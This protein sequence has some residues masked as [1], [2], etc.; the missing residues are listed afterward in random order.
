MSKRRLKYPARA[1]AVATLAQLHRLERWTGRVGFEKRLAFRLAMDLSA[2]RAEAI[3]IEDA[4][5]QLANGAS[6]SEEQQESLLIRLKVRLYSQL[7]DYT[8]RL[9]GNLK[10]AIQHLSGKIVDDPEAL[11]RET[12][13]Y[14]RRR[15]YAMRRGAKRAKKRLNRAGNSKARPTSRRLPKRKS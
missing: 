13:E 7:P 11:L 4:I 1:G 10:K 3:I 12:R 9:R 2:L 15:R 6:L 5:G 8:K 14:A